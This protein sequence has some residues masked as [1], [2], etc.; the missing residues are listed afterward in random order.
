MA[1]QKKHQ[2]G[3]FSSSI[4]F[5]I[6]C[7]G[8]AVGLG[9][10]WL[11]PYRLGQYGGAA[12]LI[13]YL[14]FVFLFGWVGLSAEFGIGRLAGTGT[15]G[16]YERCFQERDPRLKRVGSVVS[17][18][19]LMGSL[20]IAIGYAVT[21]GWVLN[22]LAGALSGTLMTAEPTAFFT[23]AASHFGNPLWHTVVI[24]MV[25]LVLMFGVTSGIEKVSRILMPLFYVLF[26]ILAIWV[27]T[28]PGA[29]EGYRF[30]LVPDWSKLLE[31][32]TWVMAMG[33][34][35]FSLSITGSGM[36]VYGAYLDK[37]EDIPK[38]SLRT[39][40]FDTMAALLSALAIMP[41][42][43]A[44]GLDVK[45]GPP[46]MFIT[47]PTVFQQ[48]PMG[49]LFAAFFFLSVLFAGLTSLINMFEAVSESWQTHF[50]LGRKTAV[51][52]CS[53]LTIG[54]GIFMESEERVGAWMDFITIQVVP[55]GAVLGAISIYY[56]LGWS[57]LRK[58]LETGRQK[59]LS[60][61]FG[62]VGKYVYVPLTI[63]VVILGFVFHGIG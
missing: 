36:I 26:I 1:N 50:K 47:L 6:A 61:A 45:S 60:R 10:I 20:G 24:A 15:I 38:A 16:A 62:P 43:F 40:I 21:L 63:L 19:P 56:V 25:C 17:W 3:G 14:L 13:P 35:F 41:A 22:S 9:N 2:N 33:Q 48:M 54:V 57:K 29:G 5:V 4:G 32:Y 42:V 30:L 27:A 37:K 7:V 53:A 46:L 39:A 49:R 51:V 55:I 44:Y 52:I 8:S 59:P 23:A 31:P 58:E 12:F 28:L 34:A 18:L 11:F